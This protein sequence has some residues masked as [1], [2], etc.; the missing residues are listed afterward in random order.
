MPL[1][2]AVANLE[3]G[4]AGFAFAS[5]MAATATI[6]ELLDAGSHIGRDA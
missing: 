5:G 1:Q 2:A 6:L 3:G 4:Y